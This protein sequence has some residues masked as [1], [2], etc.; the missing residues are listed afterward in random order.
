[1]LSIY[2]NKPHVKLLNIDLIY[3]VKIRIFKHPIIYA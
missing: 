3:D 1:L 2:F